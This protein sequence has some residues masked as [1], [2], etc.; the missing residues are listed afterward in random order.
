VLNV[1]AFIHPKHGVLRAVNADQIVAP[2]VHV[3]L[4]GLKN[5]RVVADVVGRVRRCFLIQN[6]V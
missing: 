2:S 4:D 3:I 6:G 1:L 5:V